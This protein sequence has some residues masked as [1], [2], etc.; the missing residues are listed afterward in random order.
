[1]QGDCYA[2]SSM[3]SESFLT[4]GCFFFSSWDKKITE[5]LRFLFLVPIISEMNRMHPSLEKLTSFHLD[6]KVRT[7]GPRAMLSEGLWMFR[8]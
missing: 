5:D 7:V 8:L 2:R 4:C 3:P 1:M 6:R